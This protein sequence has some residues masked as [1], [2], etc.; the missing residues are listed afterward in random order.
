MIVAKS[1][2]Y[3]YYKTLYSQSPIQCWVLV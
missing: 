3:F 1:R 2:R